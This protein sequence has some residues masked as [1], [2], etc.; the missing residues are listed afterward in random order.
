M[1]KTSSLK[2]KPKRENATRSRKFHH[3][4]TTKTAFLNSHYINIVE[5]WQM[6]PHTLKEIRET[7][8]KTSP[9]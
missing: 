3:K 2:V 6:Y 4:I 5:K 9:L 1:T 8:V 7:K